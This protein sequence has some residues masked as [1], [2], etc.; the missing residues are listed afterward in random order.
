MQ[1]FFPSRL[2]AP[3]LGVGLLFT[4]AF[5]AAAQFREIIWVD[6]DFPPGANSQVNP[7]NHPHS[8]VTPGDGQQV[9]F[10][11]KALQ[12]SGTGVAQ[13]FF[14]TCD[15]PLLVCEGDKLFAHVFINANKPTR[16]IMLQF[17]TSGWNHRAIWGAGDAV[18]FGT[19]GTPQKLAM[20]PLPAAGKWT[21]LEVEASKLG[22]VPGMEITGMAFTICDGEVFFDKAGLATTGKE[23][24]PGEKRDVVW[25]D[26]DFPD[27]AKPEVAGAPAQWVTATDGKVHAGQRALKRTGGG[28]TQDFFTGATTPLEV[29]SG[30]VL[31]AHVFLDPTDK[32]MAVMLQFNDGN[33]EHRAIWGDPEGIKWGK[34]NTA[35]RR[36]LGPLPE[37]GKWIRLEVPVSKVG[38]SV[39][40][41]LN[42]M[43]FTHEG[44]T[45][46]WDKAGLMNSGKK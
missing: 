45:V 46:Y 14:S 29:Q 43:A 3:V 9:F 19:L 34:L 17:H 15:Q 22:L 21:R 1:P 4:T 30:D 44:G 39:G 35:S 10:G 37:A 42:G 16:A 2:V 13:D 25:L 8:W 36:P 20:G 27:G 38:L 12:R 26:D 41:K 11:K 32:A 23:P 6:D 5:P 40:A 7:D 31:Y 28:P 33:W 18:P 24:P